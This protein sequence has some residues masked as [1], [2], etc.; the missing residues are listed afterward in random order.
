MASKT[1]HLLWKED[2]ASPGKTASAHAQEP[3]SPQTHQD[4]L[5]QQ[6]GAWLEHSQLGSGVRSR[7]KTPRNPHPPSR[8]KQSF[9]QTL[10][11]TAVMSSGKSTAPA[12]LPLELQVS[13]LG[14]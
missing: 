8:N 3:S 14:C 12:M 9:G 5:A 2:K 7:M 11:L 10:C 4:F 13:L 1:N 6:H